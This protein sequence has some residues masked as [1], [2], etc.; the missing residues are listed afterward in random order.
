[1]QERA[2][3][4]EKIEFVWDSVVDEVVDHPVSLDEV[5]LSIEVEVARGRAPA[6]AVLI[7]SFP[8]MGYVAEYR[9]AV[10]RDRA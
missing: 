1:M 5:D 6:E 7:E 8:F 4:H 3:N 2:L 10:P 9:I